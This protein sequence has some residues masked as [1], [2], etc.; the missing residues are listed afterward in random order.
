[1][2]RLSRVELEASNRS[3]IATSSKDDEPAA[4]NRSQ[5]VTG[6]QKHR[7][8]RFPPFAFTEHGAIMARNHSQQ[9]ARRGIGFT[10]NFDES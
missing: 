6:S 2:F 5:T 10:A 1:M 8:P 4:S 7:N 9:P 3:Q